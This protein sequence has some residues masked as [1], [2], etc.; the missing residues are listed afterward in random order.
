M[1]LP[2]IA[3]VLEPVGAQAAGAVAG[4]A[5]VVDVLDAVLGLVLAWPPPCASMPHQ[6]GRYLQ[7]RMM[8]TVPQM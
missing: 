8:P 2:A 1:V 3:G 5:G 6:R 4:E 7:I